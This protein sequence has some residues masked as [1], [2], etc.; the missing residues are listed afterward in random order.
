MVVVQSGMMNKGTLS[1]NL[2]K[3]WF[4][5]NNYGIAF[6]GYV[7]QETPGHDLLRSE[8]G[9]EFSFAGK[10]MKRAC[11]VEHFR[12]TSH[13]RKEDLQDYIIT[14]KPKDLFAVHGDTDACENLALFAKE[15]LPQTNVRIPEIGTEYEISS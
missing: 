1:F 2:A 8:R 4:M 3:S 6:V 11:Q 5:R 9:K 12:F 10:K 14:V 15:N 13:A 7:D